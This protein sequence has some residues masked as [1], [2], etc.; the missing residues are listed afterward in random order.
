I[1]DSGNTAVRAFDLIAHTLTTVTSTL[2]QPIGVVADGQGHL[3]VSDQKAEAIVRVN[4]SDGTSVTV[5]GGVY[6]DYGY[7]DGTGGGGHFATPGQLVLAGQTLYVADFRL[8][9]VD[10]DSGVVT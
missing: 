10:V 6:R 8:R 3:Y 4:I 1:V 5:A 9:A 2:S 7:N